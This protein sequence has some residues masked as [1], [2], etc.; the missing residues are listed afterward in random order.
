MVQQSEIELYLRGAGNAMQ[1]SR[2]NLNLG[3]CDA[4]TPTKEG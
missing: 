3:H 1:Q 2:D 4:A